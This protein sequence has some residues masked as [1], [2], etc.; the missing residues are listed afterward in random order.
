[1]LPENPR[2][3][4]PQPTQPDQP[5]YSIDYLNEIS[6]PV[7]KSNGP[8][9]KIMIAVIL[10][11]L[12]AVALFAFTLLNQQPSIKD[13]VRQLHARLTTLQS[14]A[15]AE[16][17]YLRSSDLRSI[18]SSYQLFLTD[19]LSAMDVPLQKLDIN[20]KQTDKPL[21]AKES[22]HQDGLQAKLEDARLNAVL[23]R[24]YSRDMAYELEVARSMMRSIHAKTSSKSTKEFLEKS[25]ANLTPIAKRF[26]QF[27]SSSN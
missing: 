4:P 24:T 25:D 19:S 6:L 17:R 1:M 27:S 5:V 14:I 26:E 3:L 15:K 9:L 10:A 16:Q 8:N 12:L 23:D 7:R 22:K 2:Y 20:I 18:N 21:A 11:G 13:E